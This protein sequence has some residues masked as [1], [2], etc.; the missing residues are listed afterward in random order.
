MSDFSATSTRVFTI[1]VDFLSGDQCFATEHYEITAANAVDA[2]EL[3]LERA[4]E[5]I[6]DDPR[7]PDLAKAGYLISEDDPLDPDPA[8]PCA[9][10][11][12]KPVCPNCASDEIVRDATARWDPD[13]QSWSLSGTFDNETCD[14]CGAEGDDFATWIAVPPLSPSDDFMWRVAQA[15]QRNDVAT[16]AEFQLFC[17]NGFDRL[18]V[19]QAVEE[20]RGRSKSGSC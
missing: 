4:A 10:A 15:L 16:D 8:A 2:I 3:A 17:L 20:W 11:R 13:A 1:A 9:I 5:S 19:E 12:S 14:S 6:Y 7:V 18:T